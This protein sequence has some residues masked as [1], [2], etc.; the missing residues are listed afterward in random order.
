MNEERIKELFSDEAF[1][2][3]V[4][5]LETPEEVQAAFAEKDVDLSVAE[6][7]KAYE[8][9]S[10]HEGEELSEEDLEQVAGGELIV[11]LAVALACALGTCGIAVG[12]DQA[13]RR[14]W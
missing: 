6:I 9:L 3:E 8:I 5:A 4:L 12:A 2:K 14:R 10:E 13:R 11:L 7:Q 1:V